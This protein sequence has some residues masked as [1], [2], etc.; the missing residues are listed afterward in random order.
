MM[1]YSSF[2]SFERQTVC[3]RYDQVGQSQLNS[4]HHGRPSNSSRLQLRQAG[5]RTTGSLTAWPRGSL[6]VPALAHRLGPRIRARRE[7]SGPS[8]TLSTEV[9]A[10][11]AWPVSANQRLFPGWACSSPFSQPLDGLIDSNSRSGAKDV[12]F[13][14]MNARP[15]PAGL[16]RE[17]RSCTAL[18]LHVLES[19]LR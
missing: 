11:A 4:H 13:P 7:R 18:R 6:L 14:A 3:V 1:D 8:S 15:V 2:G 10:D 19:T 16:V 5:A 12:A 17:V 9:P